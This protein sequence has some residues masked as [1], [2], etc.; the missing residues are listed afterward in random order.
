MRT[1]PFDGATFPD[2]HISEGGRR[3]LLSLLEQLSS[4]QIEELFTSSR[5]TQYDSASLD[6]R[7]AS[8]WVRTFLDKVRQIREGGP[9]PVGRPFTPS[10]G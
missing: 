3:K 7:N 6:S 8:L 9:C 10:A 4:T 5:M 1:L 2:G